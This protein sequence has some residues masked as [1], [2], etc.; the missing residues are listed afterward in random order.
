MLLQLPTYEITKRIYFIRGTQVM[1]DKDLA[2]LYQVET[3]N[4]KKAVRRNTERFP[5]DFMFELTQEE[6]KTLRFQIGTSKINHLIKPKELRGG[7][8][9][10]SFA[11]TEAGVA[12]LSSVLKSDR[13]IQV[14]IS[15]IRAFIQLR[16]NELTKA[17]ETTKIQ[18]I[19]TQLEEL[20]DQL[21][22]IMSQVS[23]LEET[24]T[25]HSNSS[26]APKNIHPRSLHSI[27]DIKSEVAKYFGVK[28]QE[29]ILEGRKKSVTIPRQLVMYLARKH[30]GMS[31]SQ[32]GNHLGGKNHTTVIHACRKVQKSLDSR[33]DFKEEILAIEGQLLLKKQKTTSDQS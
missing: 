16:Q 17:S 5:E 28:K 31:F 32:I 33:S 8:R 6:S 26:S 21:D 4:L 18:S 23:P 1:I 22:H 12:M 3:K 9:V 15:I 14:N 27:E 30:L 7:D 20:K 10:S 19:R 13:A 11:F 2:K 25:I 24:Q 29:L